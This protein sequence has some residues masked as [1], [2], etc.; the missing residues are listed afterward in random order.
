MTALL[1]L[2]DVT[3]TFGGVVANDAISLGVEQ[4]SIVGLIG[5]NGSGKTT[6]LNVASGVLRPTAGRITV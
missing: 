1:E 6:L 4:G 5:P 2:T 3:K